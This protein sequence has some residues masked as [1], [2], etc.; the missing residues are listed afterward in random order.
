MAYRFYTRSK[1]PPDF[2]PGMSHWKVI[3]RAYEHILCHDLDKYVISDVKNATNPKLFYVS[4]KEWTVKECAIV[5]EAWVNM[6]VPW[7]A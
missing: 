5:S 7:R 6:I 4:S 1:H 3:M 2:A